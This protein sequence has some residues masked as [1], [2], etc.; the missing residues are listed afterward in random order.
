MKTLT[1]ASLGFGAAVLLAGIAMAAPEKPADAEIT[2]TQTV[3][4]I[5]ADGKIGE[6]TV[7]TVERTDRDTRVLGAFEQQETDAFIV[8]NNE[9]DLFIN[10]LVPIQELPDTDLNVEV[11]DTYQIEYRGMVFTNTVIDER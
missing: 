5:D 1:T 8:Q 10:H 9:G 6:I 3:R 4:T 2:P 11:L 7:Y